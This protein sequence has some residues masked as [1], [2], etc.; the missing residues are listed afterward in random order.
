M[1]LPAGGTM[2]I[3]FDLQPLIF[4]FASFFS[5]GTTGMKMTSCG[6]IRRAGHLAFKNHSSMS[7][8]RMG[9]GRCHAV[10]VDA[11]KIEVGRILL[12]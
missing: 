10:F 4:R 12:W 3:R 9:S 11:G 8:G 2:L 7:F 6:G 1:R 5:P